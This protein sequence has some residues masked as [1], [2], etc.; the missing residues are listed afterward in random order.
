M[1]VLDAAEVRARTPMPALVQAIGRAFAAGAEVPQRH[2][3]ALPGDVSLLLMPAWRAGGRLG[4][5]TVTVCP[6]NAARGLPGVQGLYSLFDAATGVPLAL[7]EG[8]ELTARRTAATSALA[9]GWLARADA[10]HLL[11]VGAGRVAAVLPEAMRVV[12]PGLERLTVWARRAAAAQALAAQ[13]REQGLPAEATTD[14]AA[15]VRSADIVSCAT[16]AGEPLVH[17]DWLA[18]G[19]HLDLIG[20]FAPH[21]READTAAFAGASV[22]IDTPESLAKAGELL[23][24]LEA[25]CLATDGRPGQVVGTL[26][27]L[28]GGRCRRRR[29]AEERTVFKSVGNAIED[30]A[31]AELALDGPPG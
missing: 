26:A 7:L 22:F 16:M 27:D 12:R 25:G 10:R 15:A 1:L 28:A 19:S 20:S 3:H 4:I 6:G 24:A 8:S 21:M 31:A 2:A 5:K 29:T 13:W 17:G 11:V 9:A 30:L 18:A 14:L 23:A